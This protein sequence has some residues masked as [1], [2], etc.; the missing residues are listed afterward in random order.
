MIHSWWASMTFHNGDQKTSDESW[1]LHFKLSTEI[2]KIQEHKILRIIK[3]WG[4]TILK[5]WGLRILNP[6]FQDIQS[7]ALGLNNPRIQDPKILES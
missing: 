3:S 4:E 6:K 5:S 1:K 2:H 7:W